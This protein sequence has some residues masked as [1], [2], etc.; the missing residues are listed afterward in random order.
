V[1]IVLARDVGLK[2]YKYLAVFKLII[3]G[4]V[5]YNTALYIISTQDNM[6]LSIFNLQ[7]KKSKLL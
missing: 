3:I 6:L 1:G 7:F 2:V 4:T 5:K